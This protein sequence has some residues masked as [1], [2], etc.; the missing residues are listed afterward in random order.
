M[1][2]VK[3]FLFLQ[4]IFFFSLPVLAQVDT[5]WVRRYNGPGNQYDVPAALVVD[6]SGNVYV[7]GSSGTSEYYDKDD[8]LT[9]K[10]SPNGD[11]LWVRRYNGPGNGDDSPSGLAVDVYGNVYVTGS[12]DKDTT[13]GY[14]DYDFATIKYAPNGDTL[15][16]RRYKGPGLA[17]DEANGLAVDDSGNVYVTGNSSGATLTLEDYVTIKY[18][19]NGDTLWV[20][21]YDGP[22]N[23][24]DY[25]YQLAVDDSANVYV[26]GVID[27]CSGIFCEPP[28]PGD[29][30]TI[31]YASNGDTLWVRRYNGSGNGNDGTSALA[32]DDSGNVYVTGYSSGSGTF[33][34]YATIKYSSAGDTLWVRRYDGPGNGYDRG[35]AL[36]VD[37]SGNVYVTGSSTGS[38]S[39]FDYTTIKY[40][41]AGDTVW[42]RRYN[43]PGNGYDGGG[44]LAVDDSGNVYVTG[45][46]SPDGTFNFDYATIKYSSSGDTLWVRRYNGP[47]NYLDIASAIALDTSGNVYVTGGSS[48]DGTFNFDYATIKYIQFA[49]VAKAGDANGDGSVSLPDII[50]LVNRVFKGGPPTSPVCK[51]DANADG[52]VT[53]PD[54]IFLVNRVFKGGPAP[55]KSK[56]CCL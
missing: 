41:P 24:E 52:N 44:A 12:S 2:K 16:V 26:S 38:G 35:G 4:F 48:P 32:V 50:Y 10:Y 56:E 3:I 34:D 55:L 47:G 15:W 14:I 33:D 18:N 36:A 29:Y 43:G 37:D 30:A 28:L 51:G 5:A 25:A 1:S 31:K 27:Y 39:D 8:Y 9:I 17:S 6:G 23:H 54:I 13:A 22:S 53:L 45:A 11:T 21:R 40:S 19:P 42:V 20:R 7:T 46:S 49:C